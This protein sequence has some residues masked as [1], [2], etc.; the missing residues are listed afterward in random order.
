[1]TH[2]ATRAIP[3]KKINEITNDWVS[4]YMALN[5]LG[6]ESAA[7]ALKVCIEDMR[8]LIDTSRK[9]WAEKLQNLEKARIETEMRDRAAARWA[10]NQ[11]LNLYEMADE[12][13]LTAIEQRPKSPIASQQTQNAAESLR[14]KAVR[15]ADACLIICEHAGLDIDEFIAPAAP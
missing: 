4:R 11:A 6:D 14:R 15:A 10:A 8:H 1:M 3:H 12:Y 13:E 9:E 5:D 2:P 7:Q